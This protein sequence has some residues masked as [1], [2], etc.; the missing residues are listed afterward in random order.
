MYGQVPIR[1]EV[2]FALKYDHATSVFEVHVYKARDIAAI[3]AKR[4]SSDP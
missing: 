3:D 2:Q 1:G 4:E